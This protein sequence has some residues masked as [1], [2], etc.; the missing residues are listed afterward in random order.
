MTEITHWADVVA[1][2]VVAKRE[3][4]TISTGIT[5][6]GHIHIGNMR[7]VVTAD[8]VYR[9]VKDKGT[10]PE[11]Y[12]IA[13]NY[14]P[15]RKVY[16]FLTEEE[17]AAHVGKPISEIPCPCKKHKSYAEHFLD[18]FLKSMEKLGIHPKVLRTDELY[19]AGAFVK[20]IKTALRCRDQIAAILKEVSGKEV[21]PDWSPFNPICENC[22]K[23][24]T[25]KV[26][27]FDEKEETVSYACS[28]GKSGKVS[29]TG[30]GK[31]TWRVEWPAKWGILGVTVEPFGKDHGSSGGSY[32]SGVRIAREVFGYEPPYPIVY[33]WI[34]LGEQG[35]MSSSSGVVVS[36]SDMLDVVPPETLRFLIM[37]TKPE[38]HIKFDPGQPLLNLV[39]EYER[40]RDKE[41]ATSLEKRIVELSKAEGVKQSK[42]PFKQM[43]T[44]YQVAGGDLAQIEKIAKRSGFDEDPDV[45]NQMAKNVGVWLDKYAP[46]FAKFGV[47]D[48]VPVQCASLTNTQRAFLNAFADELSHLKNELTAEDVQRI[49]YE[50]KTAGTPIEIS[51]KKYA[52]ADIPENEI[53]PKN[54]FAAIYLALLGQTSGP[55][56]GWFLTSFDNAFLIKR[57]KEAAAYRP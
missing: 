26:T 17:Y 16:P 48:T 41:E 32:D 40:L 10:R 15:L 23:I 51:M 11:F 14:D 2:E 6:S 8:A 55:K 54:F 46:S 49:V 29:M 5:P 19:K 56:A 52:G 33:E 28:C 9:A 7:E 38:K 37:K 22:L 45:I 35:A 20:S 13:D 42:I 25:A 31:L 57:F 43:V 30:G 24:N 21:Q 27:G 12:Y 44:I 34:M 50:T 53:D 39:D 36:I 18:P 4:N 1:E 3:Q 47:K